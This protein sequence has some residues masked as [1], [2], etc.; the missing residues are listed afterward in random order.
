[1]KRIKIGRNS[2]SVISTGATERHEYLTYANNS[3]LDLKSF[4]QQTIL[5]CEPSSDVKACTKGSLST[6]GYI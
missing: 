1:M 6:A 3:T 5:E 2:K 4:Q